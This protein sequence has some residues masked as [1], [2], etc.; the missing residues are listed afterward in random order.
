LPRKRHFSKNFLEL[1]TLWQQHLQIYDGRLSLNATFNPKNLSSTEG[2]FSCDAFVPNKSKGWFFST[3]FSLQV[4]QTRVPPYVVLPN[5]V[6]R[7]LSLL[8]E[9]R[10]RT[11]GT[12]LRFCYV[13]DYLNFR[14]LWFCFSTANRNW[15]WNSIRQGS[16]FFRRMTEETPSGMIFRQTFQHSLG[17]GIPCREI[18]FAV[19]NAKSLSLNFIRCR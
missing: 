6:L 9:S 18:P 13:V 16:R 4:R 7:V 15:P 11:L 19:A 3:M 10:E 1:T 8:R 17:C 2:M 12:R 14:L 5:L